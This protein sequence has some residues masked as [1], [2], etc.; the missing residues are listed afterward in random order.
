MKKKKKKE[1]QTTKARKLNCTQ[2][3]SL[4]S[5]YFLNQYF[6]TNFM[7][8]KFPSMTDHSLED[9]LVLCSDLAELDSPLRIKNVDFFSWQVIWP[10]ITPFWT[11]YQASLSQHELLQDLL[12]NQVGQGLQ[13]HRVSKD[14]QAC[15]G[16]QEILV[17]QEDQEKEVGFVIHLWKI[18]LDFLIHCGEFCINILWW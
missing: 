11:R 8:L 3:L 12:G 15:K 4:F 9:L 17:N 1:K 18:D 2:Y 10:D 16:S 6:F 14:H 13:G 7:L 5:V